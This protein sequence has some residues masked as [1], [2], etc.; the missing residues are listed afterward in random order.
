MKKPFLMVPGSPIIACLTLLCLVFA[1][2]PA[3]A[4]SGSHRLTTFRAE[5][6]YSDPISTIF[7]ARARAGTGALSHVE[8]FEITP[9]YP[10]TMKGYLKWFVEH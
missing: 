6:K 7:L 9:R 3:A 1:A 4:Q 5:T 2:G 10:T 8:V